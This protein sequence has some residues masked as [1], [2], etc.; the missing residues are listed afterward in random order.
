M[1]RRFLAEKEKQKKEEMA[2]GLVNESAGQPINQVADEEVVKLIPVVKSMAKRYLGKDARLPPEQDIDDTGQNI[3]IEFLLRMRMGGIKNPGAYLSGIGR[4]VCADSIKD[5][6]EY[7]RHFGTSLSSEVGGGGESGE[8][9]QTLVDVIVDPDCASQ[10]ADSPRRPLE[11]RKLR[12]DLRSVLADEPAANFL[13]LQ[14]QGKTY[15]EIAGLTGL[16]R[17]Q[18]RGQTTRAKPRLRQKLR[19]RGYNK[20]GG[21]K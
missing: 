5:F 21:N 1:R 17:D 10:D 8:P 9:G 3:L 13:R 18:V 14:G 7:R 11:L 19:V 4:R 12:D 2:D 16:T 15:A 6:S 20:K